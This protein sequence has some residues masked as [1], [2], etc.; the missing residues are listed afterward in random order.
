MN[1]IPLFAGTS[2]L[3][4]LLAAVIGAT[5]V[6]S[7]FP[8]PSM[9]KPRRRVARMV[10]ALPAEIAEHNKVVWMTSRQVRR[11][12]H[13]LDNRE[14]RRKVIAV[15]GGIRQLKRRKYE[16]R[17]WASKQAQF[18]ADEFLAPLSA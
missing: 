2:R 10:T 8:M 13:F 9:P 12:K 7:A 11:R 15:E 4:V 3:A 6:S 18:N 16:M 14:L 1:R 17:G 5:G